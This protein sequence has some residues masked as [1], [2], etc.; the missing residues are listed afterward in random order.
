MIWFFAESTSAQVWYSTP[1]FK[2]CVPGC[3]AGYAYR[4][5]A[6]LMMA[7]ELT[8]T[9]CSQPL[10]ALDEQL[11]LCT[12]T[13]DTYCTP[14][15]PS[16]LP[17]EEFYAA[18]TCLTRCVQGYARNTNADM[19]CESCLSLTCPTGQDLSS[20]C[21]APQERLQLPLCLPCQEI[22]APL[23]MPSSGR[24]FVPGPGCKTT[25][26]PAWMKASDV[27]LTCVP[28]DTSGCPLGYLGY[29]AGG[30]L[31][32]TACRW[33]LDKTQTFAG[34]GNCSLVCAFPYVSRFTVPLICELPPAQQE[35]A[36]VAATS[37]TSS[38]AI[39][40]VDLSAIQKNLTTNSTAASNYDNSTASSPDNQA[41]NFPLRLL[42]HS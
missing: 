23:N 16:L 38:P 41:A 39:W 36:A 15:P 5:D 29:C 35:A 7:D 20:L 26:A 4:N 11:V 14:C 9:Q 8:C 3:E 34:P 42:P 31:Q 17:N 33:P 10:C 1:D 12:P 37:P 32:C 28:C 25:C 2:Q 21:Q 40:G 24:V 19:T 27:N 13:N 6:S 30:S 22:A 18:G